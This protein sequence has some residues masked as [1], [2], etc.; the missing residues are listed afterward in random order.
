MFLLFFEGGVGVFEFLAVEELRQKKKNQNY[1]N[2]E[3]F[4]II[5][6]TLNYNNE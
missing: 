4:Q 5:S 3:I 2:F 6:N 1:T